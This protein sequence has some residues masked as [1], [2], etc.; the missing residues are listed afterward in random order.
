MTVAS[1]HYDF[2]QK[3]NRLDS[4]KYSDLQVPEIDWKLN[5]A[6]EVF[7]KIVAQPKM[8][9]QYGF[10]LNQRSTD[11]I[12]TLVTNQVKGKG[13][14]LSIFDSNDKSY[15]ATLPSDYWFF[16]NATLYATSPDCLIAVPLQTRETQH[17]DEVEESPYNKSSFIWREANIR[18]IKEGIRVFTNRGEF[19]PVELTID[20]LLKP[21]PI[22]NASAWSSSGYY[23]D[24]TLLTGTQDCILPSTV[25]RDIVDLAV[26]ITAGDLGQ[27]DYQYKAAKIKVA[28]T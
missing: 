18:F 24:N 25:H 5:E 26:L 21:T 2:K 20:Y 1:M 8:A 11:D 13:Q 15:L 7:V 17:D 4:Q 23:L 12:R 16:L 3:L 10:E 14:A 28:T 19:I 22:Y 9:K 27:P 6:Q